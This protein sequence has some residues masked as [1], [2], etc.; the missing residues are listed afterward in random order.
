VDQ[1]YFGSCSA[2]FNI[3][4]GWKPEVAGPN[5]LAFHNRGLCKR[6][7]YMCASP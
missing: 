5:W 6:L 4:S 7:P 3:Y 2:K 1:D